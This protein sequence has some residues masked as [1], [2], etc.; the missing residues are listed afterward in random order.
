ML[1]ISA[2]AVGV[3]YA[4]SS[5]SSS[6]CCFVII[7]LC[8]ASALVMYHLNVY[9]FD[10]NKQNHH[11]HHHHHHRHHLCETMLQPFTSLTVNVNHPGPR[12]PSDVIITCNI[13][14]WVNAHF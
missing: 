3:V 1:L 4:F 12:V 8:I 9:I 7:S 10:L 11:H 13:D 2:F 6:S 5:S 14:D